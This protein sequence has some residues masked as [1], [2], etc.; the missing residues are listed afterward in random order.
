MAIKTLQITQ[1]GATVAV[2]A[3]PV[4]C[5]W[6]VFQNNAAAAMRAG[7]ANTTASRGYSI[8][9]AGTFSAPVASYQSFDTDLSQW[10][11]VGTSTQVLDVIYDE[12]AN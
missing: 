10:F 6:V 1:T 2:S 7:D 9:A 4:K 8:P 11:T 12:I 3:V 5:R